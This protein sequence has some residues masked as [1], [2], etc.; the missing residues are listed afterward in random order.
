MKKLILYFTALLVFCA[1]SL[2]AIAQE[3][4]IRNGHFTEPLNEYGW[5]SLDIENVPAG[6]EFWYVQLNQVLTQDQID[7]IEVDETYEL[8]F[9]AKANGD[10]DVAV[11][12]GEDG[13]DH[14]NILDPDEDGNNV[15]NLTTEA[16]SFTFEFE[17]ETFDAMKLG[18]EGGLDDINYSIGHV[19]ILKKVEGDEDPG[20]NIINNGHFGPS[21]FEDTWFVWYAD[22]HDPVITVSISLNDWFVWVADWEGVTADLTIDVDNWANIHNIAN[23]PGTE[24]WHVQFNQGL[25]RSQIDTLIMG[26]NYTL[27]FDAKA[28]DDGKEV[29][30]FFGQDGGAFR[31]LLDTEEEGV[32]VIDLT[33]DAQS[34][35][36]DFVAERFDAMKLGFEGGLSDVGY[37]ISNVEIL[38][39][40]ITTYDITISVEGEGTTDPEPGT[41]TWAA[42]SELELIAT[43]D[44]GWEFEKWVINGDEITEATTTVTLADADVDAVAH[45]TEEEDPNLV[46]DENT[47]NIRVYPNPAVDRLNVVASEGASIN[48]TNIMGSVVRSTIAESNEVSIDVSD[49]P[50]GVYIISVEDKGN[51]ITRK[52]MVK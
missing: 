41:Y 34:F 15:I 29:A 30:V 21:A 1:F 26:G 48:L 14:H 45:F 23:T 11:Y 10:K 16:Q 5:V 38:L 28:E 27:T 50:S 2:S 25:T 49:L 40:D 12:F 33:T 19:S 52:I 42:G 36:F 44:E 32:N 37:S 47:S 13:G 22:W 31:N 4:L 7:A 3:N 39:E 17:A 35:S 18:F 51:R 24:I 6:E 20:D 46:L 43:P 8:T 9:Y